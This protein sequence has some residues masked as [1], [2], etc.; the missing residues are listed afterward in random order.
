VSPP[1]D[2]SFHFLAE[3]NPQPV[4]WTLPAPSPRQVASE[5][6]S[7]ARNGTV[8]LVTPYKYSNVP[9]LLRRYQHVGI[10]RFIKAMEP[11]YH[12]AQRVDYSFDFGTQAVY[13]FRETKPV[14]H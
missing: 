6:Q 10:S 12:I 1:L 14:R 3:P 5:A 8:F 7:L 11:R 4:F 9:L 2:E 13:V